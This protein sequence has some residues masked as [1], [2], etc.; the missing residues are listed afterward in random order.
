[1]KDRQ[2]ENTLVRDTTNYLALPFQ[3]T[4]PD[5]KKAKTWEKEHLRKQVHIYKPSFTE[6]ATGGII[7]GSAISNNG[8]IGTINDDTTS[9]K[10]IKPVNS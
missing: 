8:T 10:Q 6:F 9:R 7:Y 2:N 1:M 3:G 5:K 4:R